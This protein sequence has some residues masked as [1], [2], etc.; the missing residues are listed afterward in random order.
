MIYFAYGSNLDWSQMKKRCPSACFVGKAV[1]NGYRFGF[2]RRSK[3]RGCGVMDIVKEDHRQVW[4]VVYQID[5]LDLGKL[6]KSEGYDPGRAKNA[7]QRIE[8]VVYENGDANRPITA[9]TYEVVE[10]AITTILPDQAYKA[11]IVN[12]AAYWRLPADYL[13]ELKVVKTQD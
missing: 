2:T 10:K 7:Y 13:N 1:L 9:M 11:L 8:C 6:D 5:E 4:G 3:N 12:G